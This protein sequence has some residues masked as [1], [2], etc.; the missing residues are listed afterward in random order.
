VQQGRYGLVAW[1]IKRND[2]EHS[3]SSIGSAE[4]V[5][6][7]ASKNLFSL[8]RL[9]PQARQLHFRT[10]IQQGIRRDNKPNSQVGARSSRARLAKKVTYQMTSKHG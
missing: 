10:A 5:I 6:V 4:R 9:L 2:K 1:R 3:A 7:E 8:F